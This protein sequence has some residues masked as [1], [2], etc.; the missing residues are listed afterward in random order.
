MG[1]VDVVDSGE[2]EAGDEDKGDDEYNATDEGEE[3]EGGGGGD[4]AGDDEANAF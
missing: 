2:G 3:N 4:D 1:V